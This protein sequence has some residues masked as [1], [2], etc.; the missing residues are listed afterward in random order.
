MSKWSHYFT[1]SS[2]EINL[3]SGTL[4]QSP[5]Q[6]IEAKFNY[7]REYEKNTTQSLLNTWEKL[8]NTQQKLA[9]WF[10][11]NPND[12]FLRHNITEALN[13]LILGLPIQTGEIAYTDLEYGAIIN[14]CKLK[15]QKENLSLRKLDLSHYL[16]SSNQMTSEKAG[17]LAVDWIISQ[18]STQTRLLLV[19]HVMTLNGLTIPIE[20]LAQETQKR[21]IFLVVDGAHAIGALP[22]DFSKFKNV[23]A[24][25]GNLHKWMMAP[26]GTGFGWLNPEWQSQLQPLNGSWTVFESRREYS[27]F[28]NGSHFPTMM[29]TSHCQD[30]SSWFAISETLK[31]WKEEGEENIRTQINTFKKR[32]RASFEDALGWECVSPQKES[33]GPLTAF[34][35]PQKL[36]EQYGENL[37]FGIF[38]NFKIQISTPVPP[39]QKSTEKTSNLT[40]A[41]YF[42]RFSPHI[43]NTEEEILRAVEI[44]R[45]KV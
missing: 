4:S 18:L 22:L 13:D 2:D 35:A 7:Y 8:W 43:I 11:G 23:S 41:N 38:N 19:S 17:S 39:Q 27:K 24:Y 21:G 6:V 25:T 26:K 20:I 44:F 37:N 12:F 45:T 33:W 31:F 5:D 16:F 28:A 9:T 42:I 34:R 15:A 30:F 36:I 29:L 40:K 1:K 3:N 10:N 32:I 14:I